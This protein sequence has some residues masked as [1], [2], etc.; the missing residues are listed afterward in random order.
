MEQSYMNYNT[1]IYYALSFSA[2]VKAHS[3]SNAAKKA[4]VSKAQLSRHVS[5]LETMLGIQ[6][7][8]RTTRSIAL[9]EQGKQFFTACEAIEESCAE[10]VN[11]LRHDFRNMHGNLKITAPID[12]G[13]QFLPPIID[14]FSKQ[15]PNM[16]VVLSLSNANE[17]LTEQS[18]DLAIRIA[19]QLPDSNLRMRTIMK[20]KRFICVTPTYFKSKKR[21]KNLFELKDHQCITSINHNTNNI[22]PQWQFIINKKTVNY[23][24]EKYIQVDS[25]S[26]QIALIKLGTGIGRMPSY[27]IQNELK[28]GELIEVFPDIEKPDSFVYVLYPDTIVL[29]KKT[30][31]FIDFIKNYPWP[32][33]E[34]YARNVNDLE[35]EQVSK[36][37]LTI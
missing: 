2:V 13:I 26:A 3:F 7:L 34:G 27:L 6:L 14:Q 37:L 33:F 32:D 4:G 25:L 15:Y 22:Y 18:Y 31:L 35:S 30:R 5:A 1:L 10:A 28:S 12:F 29:P 20:F 19:T 21:P 8:H 9:T 24:L 17:N 16:N 23:K 36:E 11:D